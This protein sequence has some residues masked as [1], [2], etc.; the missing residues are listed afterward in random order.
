MNIKP[1]S[2]LSVFRSGAEF[3]STIPQQTTHPSLDSP[4][5]TV[6]YTTRS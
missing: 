5:P 3:H 2:L 1:F 6:T 4:P